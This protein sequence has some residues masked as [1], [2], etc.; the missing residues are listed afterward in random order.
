MNIE[1]NWFRVNRS[2]FES[3]LWLSESFTRGQAWI[4]LVGLAN[5]TKGYIRVR[6]NRINLNRGDV[7]YSIEKLRSRWRWSR[8]KVENWLKELERDKQITKHEC[9]I[10]TV[11]TI[12]NY[13]KYQGKGETESQTESQTKVQT[14]CKSESQ[15]ESQL[16]KKKKKNNKKERKNIVPPKIEWVRERMEEMG[17]S[18]FDAEDYFNHWDASGWYRGKVKTKNWHASLATWNPN[19][20]KWG[21]TKHNSSVGQ[22]NGKT[23]EQCSE[24]EKMI[25]TRAMWKENLKLAPSLEKA[26]Q[27]LNTQK[28][29]S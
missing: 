29:D 7:G 23:Y 25:I 9:R 6:G 27:I 3:D 8:K 15:I 20:K 18:G 16:I 21:K 13:E 19:N 2:L 17:Y 28:N 5:H 11:I 22:G 14:E 1:K 4:D 10:S 24:S 26:K 12:K